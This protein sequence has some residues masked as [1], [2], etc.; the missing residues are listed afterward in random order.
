MGY[1]NVLNENII[2]HNSFSVHS[3]T[4]FVFDCLATRDKQNILIY[5]VY[6]LSNILKGFCRS[7]MWALG[8]NPDYHSN[9][10]YERMFTFQAFALSNWKHSTVMFLRDTQRTG[11][12]TLSVSREIQ[13]N[14]SNSFWLPAR[15]TVSPIL[16]HH[17]GQ[18]PDVG[19]KLN[20]TL[21][22][23]Q[24]LPLLSFFVSYDVLFVVYLYFIIL[25]CII[26]K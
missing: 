6:Y 13:S 8:H 22:P 7:G 16:L 21:K 10:N 25:N 15:E 3:H 4:A 23:L 9:R 20:Q 19:F 12:F 5:K 26:S 11:I 14:C 17:S 24:C 2:L 1:L 18:R